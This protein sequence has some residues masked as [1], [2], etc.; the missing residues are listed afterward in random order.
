MKILACTKE[1]KLCT[2][3][4]LAA[5]TLASCDKILGEEDTD[6]SMKYCVRFKYD[7]NMKYADAGTYYLQQG[8]R[9]KSSF[10]SID[11]LPCTGEREL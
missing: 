10:Y 8:D 5:L 3:T 9:R 1:M 11:R 7:Y 4:V 2:F 6:C